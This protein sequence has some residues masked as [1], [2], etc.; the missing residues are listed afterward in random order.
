MLGWGVFSRIV[1]IFPRLLSSSKVIPSLF[2]LQHFIPQNDII[3]FQSSESKQE[4]PRG[5]LVAVTTPSVN[6][7][8]TLIVDLFQVIINPLFFQ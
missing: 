5:T 1:G 6:F 8:I 4:K 2:F 3:L 7:F